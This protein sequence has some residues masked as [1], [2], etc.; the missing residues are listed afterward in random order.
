MRKM[1]KWNYNKTK[2]QPHKNTEAT[3]RKAEPVTKYPHKQTGT[4]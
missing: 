3:Q 1:K 4:T 2:K